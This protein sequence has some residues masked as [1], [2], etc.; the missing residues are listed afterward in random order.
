MLGVARTEDQTDPVAE[1][2]LQLS[3]EYLRAEFRLLR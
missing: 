2:G 1:A 3:R